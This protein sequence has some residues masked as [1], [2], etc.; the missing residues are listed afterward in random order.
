MQ[1]GDLVNIVLDE[2]GK[3]NGAI[4]IG[5]PNNNFWSAKIDTANGMMLLSNI[6]ANNIDVIKPF[7]AEAEKQIRID[8]CY[9]AYR[10]WHSDR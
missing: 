8:Q 4:L 6:D 3:I 7:D 10:K 5:E 2:H 1:A 9:R